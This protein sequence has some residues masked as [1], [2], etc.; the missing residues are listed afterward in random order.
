M[1]SCSGS[2]VNRWVPCRVMICP[3]AVTS[4]ASVRGSVLSD[5]GS[6]SSGV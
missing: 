2:G 4:V 3:V 6:C 1:V 5:C